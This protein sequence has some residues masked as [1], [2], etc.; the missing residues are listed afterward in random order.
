MEW[1]S[2]LWRRLRMLVR[3]MQRDAGLEDEIR[4]HIELRA[5][6]QIEAGAAPDEAFYAARRR[7]GNPMLLKE[8]SREMW[9]WRWLEVLLQDIRYGLRMLTKNPG[10]TTAVLLSLVLGIG[11]NTA[12]FS[13]LNAVVLKALPVERP[14]QLVQFSETYSQGDENSWMSFPYFVRIRDRNLTLSSVFA[15]TG[16]G[17][18]NLGFSG[19][20]DLAIGQVATGAYFSTLGVRPAAGRLF[21]DEDDNARR[22]VAVISYAF[23]QRRFGGDPSVMGKTI[24]LNQVPFTLIGVTPAPFF[25]LQ[26]GDSP[27]ITLPMTALDRLSTSPP[28]W[29]GAFDSWIQI[30]GRLKPEVTREEAQ[31]EFKVIHHQVLTDFAPTVKP[32]QRQFMERMLRTSHLNVKPGAKGFEG[33][34]HNFSLPLQMLMMIVGMVLLIACANV[35]NLLL[36]RAAVRQK[37]I[38]VRLAIGAG[39]ARLIRQLLTESV[40]LAS[41]GGIL[42]FLV[43]WWGSQVLLRMVSTGDSLLPVDLTP[44]LRILAFTAG[45]S[46]L[47]GILFG[48]APSLRATRV[49]LTPALKEG[50]GQI[51]KTEHQRIF[52]LDKVLVAAQ[53]ALS[54]TLLIGGG[55]FVRSLHKLWAIDPG[56]D[57]HNVLM[58]SLDPR[59]AGY[60]DSAKLAALYQELL[61]DIRSLPGVRSSSLSLVRPV[62]E[63]VYWVNVVESVDGRKL[64]EDQGIRGIRVAVNRLGPGYFATMGTP[65]LLGR[66]FGLEDNNKAPKVAVISEMLAHQCFGNANPIGRRIADHDNGE[67]QVVGVVNGSRYGGVKE[68]P[69]SVLYLPFFQDNLAEASFAATFEIRYSGRLSNVL[70]GVRRQVL[71]IDR[72]FPLFRVKTLEVQTED[73]LVKE[74]L[75]ATLSAFFG[76]LAALLACI[77][78]YGT[79]AYAVARRTGEIGL[80]MALGAHRRGVIWMVLRETVLLI[81]IGILMGLLCAVGVSHLLASQL[82]GVKPTD[83]LTLSAASLLLATVAMFAG[84]VPA[85]RASRVDPMVALRYE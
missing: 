39:R 3:R 82:Y 28:D 40:L 46:L 11:A 32:D 7:F 45:V 10:V 64:P 62:D 2:E 24:T 79:M 69:R 77:G 85:R 14:E 36:A 54:L 5:G 38:A 34:R 26:V 6:E 42:G 13:L 53:V 25:G 51:S 70:D 15:F 75:I 61:G 12:I 55:L 80:R 8:A 41:L 52:A 56:Y 17:R 66:E 58:F 27:D 30:M 33:L 60:N 76:M 57:R 49:D 65:M 84:Y 81:A 22:P 23:W 72:N 31:A 35:A 44:D 29:N 68:L 4:L 50:R 20:A 78:L 59:L 47:T 48:L 16:L 21:T 43:A 63:E 37:E 9:G 18:V 67:F 71:A 74:R 83:V 1:L 19:K 73:S